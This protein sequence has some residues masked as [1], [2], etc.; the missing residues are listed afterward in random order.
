M[1][2]ARKKSTKFGRKASRF[3]GRT[4]T[5]RAVAR[6]YQRKYGT[7]PLFRSGFDRVGGSYKLHGPTK[8]GGELKYIDKSLAS[9][10]GALVA[11]DDDDSRMIWS[12]ALGADL[13]ATAMTSNSWWIGQSLI[14][15][16]QGQGPSNRIGRKF[17][18]QNI[19][20]KFG[21]S[22]VPDSLA[23][24]M[25]YYVR[26]M[27]IKDSQYNG[28]ITKA[29]D[30][31]EP[32]VGESALLNAGGNYPMAEMLNMSNSQRFRI[33]RDSTFPLERDWGGFSPNEVPANSTYSGGYSAY[34]EFYDYTP[35]DIEQVGAGA[36]ISGIKSCNYLLAFNVFGFTG[37]ATDNTVTV[38]PA[39]VYVWGNSRARYTDA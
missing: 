12:T 34:R 4:T 23:A 28:G 16:K 9:I 18:L 13:P 36:G 1:P 32:V 21:V 26:V 7:Q 6:A 33:V 15:T 19:F 8:R 5:A 25:N 11:R 37:R 35:Q 29:A 17:G 30:L 20:T 22:I 14:N 27:I 3:G 2:P 24:G 10:P 39:N 38:N 31:F